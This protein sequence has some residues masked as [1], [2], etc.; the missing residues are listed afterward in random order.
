MP[1]ISNPA[2]VIK[3]I[4]HKEVQH[5]SD[6]IAV[7]DS[8]GADNNDDIALAF[9]VHDKQINSKKLIENIASNSRLIP[10]IKDN[11]LILKGIMAAPSPELTTTTLP[12]GTVG[13]VE[14]YIESSDIISYTNKRT[15]PEKVYTKVVVNYHYDYALKDFTKNTLNNSEVYD[16]ITEYFICFPQHYT[17]DDDGFIDEIFGYDI[18][19]LGLKAEQELL[20]DAHY[21]RD[22]D[23]AEALQEFLLLW[24]CNQHNVLKLR[25]PLKY[26]QLKI[27]DYIGFDKLINGVKL[28]GEDYSI[29]GWIG[30]NTF[31]NGQQILPVWMITSTNKTLTHID[32]EMIQ[33]HNC[34]DTVI[35]ALNY[36]PSIESAVLELIHPVAQGNVVSHKIILSESDTWFQIKL[37]NN[38]TDPNDDVLSYRFQH[39]SVPVQYDIGI[40]DQLVEDGDSQDLWDDLEIDNGME[41]DIEYS[42]NNITLELGDS[43][44]GGGHGEWLTNWLADAYGGEYLEFPHDDPVSAFLKT[45]VT[46][47]VFST[48]KRFPTFR[49]YKDFIPDIEVTVQISYVPGWNLIG[50]PCEVEDPYFLTLFPEAVSGTLYGFDDTYAQEATLEIGT[51]YYL[52]FNNAGSV[53]ISGTIVEPY[54]AGTGEYGIE[55]TQR[56]NLISGLHYPIDVADIVDPEGIIVPNS[57]YGFINGE[58]T[59]VDVLEVGQAYWIRASQDGTIGLR[60]YP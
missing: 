59:N 43:P 15:A 51:G 44:N 36:P 25:L 58:Y 39:A 27:G 41:N 9:T 55:L 28:F 12:D 16:T 4:I 23:S 6:E 1:L 38:A 29:S 30:G 26:I 42:E 7:D 53:T 54:G 46:D 40:K 31:R 11:T 49:V 19:N 34:S 35:D 37:T 57:I 47:G 45:V 50:L 60:V 21:I 8:D 10:Y 5:D 48:H 13:D 20:F 52:Y 56:W 32:V 2:D 17:V 3:H 14:M 22:E 33:M 24:H 18:T